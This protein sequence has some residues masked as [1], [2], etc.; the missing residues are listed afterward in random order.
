[1]WISWKPAGI[2]TGI[3]KD[4]GVLNDAPLSGYIE[5]VLEAVGGEIKRK[6]VV[7]CADVNT[8]AYHTFN[9]T[10]KDPVKAV[11]SSASIPFVFPSQI[12]PNG[13][14]DN[15]DSEELVCMD[16]GTIYNTNIVSAIERCR[17]TVD[18]DKD[19]TIDIII[20]D[21]PN[22]GAWTD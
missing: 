13:T 21:S 22:L 19:I 18:S 5:S 17:E 7:S 1:M 6:F 14:D 15:P 8:G 2:L 11:V 20:C 12:W 9:E 4:S 10:I 16:G 3:V